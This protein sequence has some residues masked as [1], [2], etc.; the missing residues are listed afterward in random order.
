M[1]SDIYAFEEIFSKVFS[2]D[3][4]ALTTRTINDDPQFQSDRP[5]CDVGIMLTGSGNELHPERGCEGVPGSLRQ[6]T[7]TGEIHVD[8]ITDANAEQH[9]E[10]RAQVR[11][12]MATVMRRINNPTTLP[13]HRVTLVKAGGCAY[14]YNPE[15]G[16]YKT[17]LI[18][19]FGF[20]IQANAFPS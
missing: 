17:T 9:G 2:D 16:F 6:K 15:G 19:E 10:Y 1:S 14:D 12:R 20:S 7:F 11:N 18:Y 5:R 3:L 13:R 8:V 4:N